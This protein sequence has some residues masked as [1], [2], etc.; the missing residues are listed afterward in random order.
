MKFQSLIFLT[1]LIFNAAFAFTTSKQA[2]PQRT[3]LITSRKT[4]VIR[5]AAAAS[6]SGG[7]KKK[8]AT[9]KKSVVKETVKEEVETVRETV[10]EEVETVRKPEFIASIA[11]KTG[12][13][14]TDS[15]AALAAVLETITEV[16]KKHKSCMYFFSF[17]L[18]YTH[19]FFH[20]PFDMNLVSI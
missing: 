16:R 10:K 3:S 14:K 9:K 4:T 15:E 2:H 19:E 11:E 8:K 12:M 13:S 7:A 17:F 20:I 18:V 1:S 5:A 6:S